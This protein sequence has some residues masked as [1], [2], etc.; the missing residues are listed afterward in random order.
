V[1]GKSFL[2]A[3]VVADSLQEAVRLEAQLT[4]LPAVAPVEG[5]ASM[6]HYLAAD[7]TRQLQLIGEIKREI[8]G[9]RFD[10]PDLHPVDLVELSR[11]LYSTYGFLGA[12]LDEI[13]TNEPALSKQLASM[14]GAI[15]KLRPQM[16]GG[17]ESVPGNPALKLATFQQA[18]FEDVR[19][20]FLALQGQDDS[21]PLR[22][23]DLPESLRDRFVGVTGKYLLQVYPRKD[24]WERENQKEFVGQLRTVDEN[25]TGSPVQLYEYTELLKNSYVQAAGYAL[26][27]IVILVLIHFRNP[28][29]VVLALLP[30][31]IGSV[32][33]GGL[34][35][36]LGI[37]LNPANIMMLPLMLGIGVTNGVHILNRFA[38]EQ[39]PN[40]LARSTGKAVLVSGL[41]TVAGFGSLIPA[42]HQGIES[43]G[44][45]MSIGVST[46]MIAGL[47][48]LPALL[49]LMSRGRRP[50]KQPSADNARSTLGREEPR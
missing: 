29:S 2:F 31:A 46:C 47:T 7:Q 3:A 50:T 48:F 34:M 18:L 19:A 10:A 12:A 28:T 49:N 14:R 41:T 6:A 8:A 27:A 23:E 5:V 25:V 1:S 4:N 35:G 43:L 16:L 22:I 36:W 26:G 9:I 40:I 30:V 42:K 32:W 33:L 38:E 17:G 11:T 24:V 37:P 15:E 44:L 20:M 45:V 39:T 13:G 21:A